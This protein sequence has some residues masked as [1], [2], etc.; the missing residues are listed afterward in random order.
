MDSQLFLLIIGIL[1]LIIFGLV[2]W[3][4]HLRFYKSTGWFWRGVICFVLIHFYFI[5]VL[6]APLFFQNLN[7]SGAIGLAFKTHFYLIYAGMIT[8]LIIVGVIVTL[9]FIMNLI[10]MAF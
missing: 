9:T 3:K 4:N 7:C 2:I 10:S 5:P 8:S 6:F 1:I